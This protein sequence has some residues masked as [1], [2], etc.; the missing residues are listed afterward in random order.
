M[1][2]V[3]AFNPDGTVLVGA[4]ARRNAVQNP[5]GTFFATK[6]LIG[7]RYDDP[8]TTKDKEMVPYEIVAAPNGDAWVAAHGM[9]PTFN[10]LLFSTLLFEQ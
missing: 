2:S 6:R 4:P 8:M 10:S 9:F 1:P 7:R 3:V 5:A